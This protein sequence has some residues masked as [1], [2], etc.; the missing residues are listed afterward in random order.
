MYLLYKITRKAESAQTVRIDQTDKKK[1]DSNNWYKSLGLNKENGQ[2]FR[3]D[4]GR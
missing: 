2:R 4:L 1:Y 3:T